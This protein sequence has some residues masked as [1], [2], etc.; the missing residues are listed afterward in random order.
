M[1][2]AFFEM[3]GSGGSGEKGERTYKRVFKLF[4][5]DNTLYPPDVWGLIPIFRYDPYPAD[6]EAVAVKVDV[7]VI[8]DEQLWWEVTYDYKTEE[9]DEGNTEQDRDANDQST[10]PPDR[11]WVIDFDS[12]QTT[13][14]LGPK[15]LDDNDVTNS[16]GVPFDPVPEVPSDNIIINITAYR[17]L[18]GFDSIAKIKTY[19]NAI[20]STAWI[21]PVTPTATTTFDA[22][23]V[24]INKFHP[25]PI[26]ENGDWYIKLEMSFEVR[27]VAWNPYKILN[28]G[29]TRI[30]DGK[31]VPILDPQG[32]Q[33][34]TA[35]PLSEL[36]GDV[37]TPLGP[38]D[39]PIYLDFKAYNEA[40]F[41]DILT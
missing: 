12:T 29:T 20:N 3:M 7:Q 37:V 24:R 4:S 40:E 36:S 11:P 35:I 19:Q 41:T 13:R 25:T 32:N 1:S 17:D 33:I 22:K 16:C 21:V 38:D 39:S 31:I 26:Q 28:A 14:L 10:D 23:T 2:F 30:V 15:D 6:E 18:D 5:T 34:T 9:A 8:S 27:D